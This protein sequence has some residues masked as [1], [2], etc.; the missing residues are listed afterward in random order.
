MK[1]ILLILFVGLILVGSVFATEQ[2]NFTRIDQNYV[3]ATSDS[4]SNL[5]IKD[6]RQ[7]PFPANPGENLDL[8]MS[9]DNIGGDI[10]NPRF[11][12]NLKYPFG[13]DAA[14]DKGNFPRIVSGEKITIHYKLRIDKDAAPGDYQ[15][16]FRAYTSPDKYYPYFFNIHVDDVTS[17]FDSVVQDVTKDGVSLAIS[18]TGKN[19]ANSITVKIPEQQDFAILG[20]PSYI[21]GNLNSGDYTLLTTLLK[22]KKQ[23]NEGDL[24]NLNL[25]IEYTD[26]IG[27]RRSVAKELPITITPQIKNGFGDLAGNLVSLSGPRKPVSAGPSLV[28]YGTWLLILILIGLVIYYRIK[29]KKSKD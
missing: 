12:L 29:A 27:N 22:P 2:L 23:I 15:V 5:R 28:T 3:A 19:V 10:M 9:A 26:T 1:K 11:E 6:I 8:Y 24:L 4:L 25:I 21:I 18:N 16:E 20:A 17:N 14:S 13:L 7:D